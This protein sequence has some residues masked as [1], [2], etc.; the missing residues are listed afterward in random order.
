[1]LALDTEDASRLL[2][3]NLQVLD[4]AARLIEAHR[5]TCSAGYR[6]PVGVHLRHVIE[7]YEALLKPTERGVV[8]YDRRARNPEVERDPGVA[9]ARVQALQRALGSWTHAAS[10]QP[11]LVVGIGGTQGDFAY[12]V[13]STGA[14]ELAFLASHA[15]HHFALLRRHCEAQRIALDPDFGRAPATVAHDRQ[16]N[17]A[18][19]IEPKD[20]SCLALESR[21]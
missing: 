21:A 5:A 9:L 10:A 2:R 3:F 19:P 6:E 14:R 16:R 12:R 20:T 1:M 8:D 11:L 18:T 13:P 17:P 7:H 4:Q 15:V